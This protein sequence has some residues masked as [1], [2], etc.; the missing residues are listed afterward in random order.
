[1]LQEPKQRMLGIA[2]ELLD[3]FESTCLQK[4]STPNYGEKE[5]SE[6]LLVDFEEDIGGESE[7]KAAESEERAA[8]SEGEVEEG[9]AEDGEDEDDTTVDDTHKD[10]PNTVMSKVYRVL[11]FKLS[12]NSN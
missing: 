2:N 10:L 7:E 6:S 12:K 1:M 8:E 9:E 11:E 4:C 5:G 3:T